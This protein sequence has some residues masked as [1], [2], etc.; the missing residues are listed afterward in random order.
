MSRFDRVNTV[1]RMSASHR[2]ERE[3]LRLTGAER[4][5][6]RPKRASSVRMRGCGVLLLSLLLL[7]FAGYTSC[8]LV[9]IVSARQCTDSH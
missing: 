8:R 7:F 2:C 1:N 5:R 9:A 4:D 3:L 6:R